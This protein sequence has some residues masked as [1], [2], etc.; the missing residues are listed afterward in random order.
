MLTTAYLFAW[1][2]AF[3]LTQLI[4]APVY[5]RMLG[6]SWPR[7]L[8]PSLVTHPL[9]WFVFP[10]L[11]RVGFSYL[12]WVTVAEVTVWLV[13]AAMLVALAGVSW[14]R[15]AFVALVGNAL[16]VAVGLL[17]IRLFGGV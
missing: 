14:R 11:S 1:L 9:V 13:E 3:A 4:E 2:R 6:V 7:A 8:L 17:A 5:R 16:S 15:A 12:A 10:L